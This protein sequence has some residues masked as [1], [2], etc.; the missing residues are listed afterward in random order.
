MPACPQPTTDDLAALRALLEA[1]RADRRH[2]LAVAGPSP[3]DDPVGVAALAA[4]ARD[5]AEI[6]A[7]LARMDA[8]TY[9]RCTCCSAAIPLPRLEARPQARGCAGCPRAERVGG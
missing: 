3:Q 4:E 6:E 2:S 7:A 1:A 9:G 8:G 5:L